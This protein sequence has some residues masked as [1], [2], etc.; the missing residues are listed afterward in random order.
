MAT[1]LPTYQYTPEED[2]PLSSA[3]IT[4]LSEA[5]GRDI[6][7]DECILYNTIDPDALNGMFR[8]QGDEDT[9]KVEFA[10]HDAIVILWGNGG[11][12]IQIEDLEDD[13]NHV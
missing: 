8:R 6:T 9:V 11:L 12:T 7:E 3:I 1:D 5:K 2:E 13:P 10:T 4:A